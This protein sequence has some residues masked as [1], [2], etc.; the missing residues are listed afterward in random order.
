M[1]QIES[2]LTWV[3]MKKLLLIRHAK[4]S[5]KSPE[6]DDHDRP[7]N[8]RGERDRHRMS[9]Y[10]LERAE[11]LDAIHSSTAVRALTLAHTIGEALKVEVASRQS[12]YTFGA[13][14]LSSVIRQLPSALNNVAVIGH[15][16]AFTE[17]SNNLTKARIDN[18]PTSGIV[19]IECNFSSWSEL[20]PE[21]CR[22]LSFVAPKLI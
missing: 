6:L 9:E 2:V 4:S 18:V 8:K 11:A 22:L 3:A 19:S 10:L 5:W 7:L 16:P 15:N 21:Q 17:L 20:N 13:G 14:A 1:P 12:L